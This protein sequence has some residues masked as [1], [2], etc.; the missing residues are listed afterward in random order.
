MY[1]FHGW[2]V[3]EDSMMVPNG[4]VPSIPLSEEYIPSSTPSVRE[5]RGLGTDEKIVFVRS[6]FIG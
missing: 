5:I 3:N 2:L 4:T 6:Y 1:S